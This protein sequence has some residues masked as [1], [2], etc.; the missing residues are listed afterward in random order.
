[1]GTIQPQGLAAPGFNP[2]LRAM[3]ETPIVPLLAR[4]GWSNM[5]M[6]LAQASTGLIE[7]WFLAKLGTS[8]L[9]GVAVVVPVLML[10]QN[11]SQGAMGGGISSAVA[12]S[13][14]SGDAELI[15]QL[16]RHALALNALIGIAFSVV[17]LAIAKPLFQMLGAHGA[18]LDAASTYGH[19]L[20]FWSAAPVGNECTCERDSRYR[21]RDRAR[22]GDLRRCGALDPTVAVPDLRLRARATIWC[23]GWCVGA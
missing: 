21:Q 19:V 1:M 16:A 4:M 9:A 23:R 22:C 7:T 13:L 5:L 6:M 8:I 11:M 20:F 12:R 10:M 2:L 14:G 15:V 18:A 3:L 17:L